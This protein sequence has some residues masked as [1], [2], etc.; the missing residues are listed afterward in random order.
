[1]SG[2]NHQQ[3]HSTVSS[4]NRLLLLLQY[5][6]LGRNEGQLCVREHVFTLVT[7]HLGKQNNLTV[8]HYCDENNGHTILLLV[9][10]NADVK[11]KLFKGKMNARP[12]LTSR[13]Q[14]PSQAKHM[15]AYMQGAI[16]EKKT[17]GGCFSNTAALVMSH[18][19]RPI[20]L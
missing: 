6:Y 12:T 11:K 13:T 14:T 15:L 5:Y 3:Q 19:L 7:I 18:T 4:S 10:T 2:V 20:E 9:M 16:C 1:M 17:E 8:Y